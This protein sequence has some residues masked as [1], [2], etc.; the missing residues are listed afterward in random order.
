MKKLV[1][2]LFLLDVRQTNGLHVGFSGFGEVFKEVLAVS[3]ED[4]RFYEVRR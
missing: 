4:V 1:S 3:I 2:K